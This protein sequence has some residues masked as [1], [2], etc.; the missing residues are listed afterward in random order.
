MIDTELYTISIRKEIVEGDS[1][2]VARIAEFPDVQEYGETF[3]EARELAV[4]T[5]E[6]AYHLCLEQNIPFPEPLDLDTHQVSGRVTLR[7]PKSLHAR[8]AKIAEDE[9]VSLNQYIVSSLSMKYGQCQMS[10]SILHELR[11]S[12]RVVK[13][14][15]QKYQKVAATYLF[16]EHVEMLE[17]QNSANWQS[18]STRLSWTN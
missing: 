13:N 15:I 4:D 6:T 16:K 5:I 9:D 18:G 2:Y 17:K 11:S 8:L 14:E 1:L 7:M 10:D 3:E 12:I